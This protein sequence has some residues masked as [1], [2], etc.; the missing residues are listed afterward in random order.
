MVNNSHSLMPLI[1]ML[2]DDRLGL[3]AR[4]ALV[5]MHSSST[6]RLTYLRRHSA[7]CSLTSL[8]R[9]PRITEYRM[10]MTQT[11][12]Q[13]LS[14]KDPGLQERPMCHGRRTGAGERSNVNSGC[15][16]QS[17]CQSCYRLRT[18]HCNRLLTVN[19]P[20]FITVSHLGAEPLGAPSGYSLVSYTPGGFLTA[21]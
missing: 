20:P 13:I 12:S 2:P 3:D 7:R 19:N 14:L 1:E 17:S 9:Q 18:I 10:K 11:N 8:G 5:P 15:R 16:V 6:M 4:M 21:P